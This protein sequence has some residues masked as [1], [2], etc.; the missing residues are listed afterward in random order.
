M[1]TL[2]SM[3]QLYSFH[4]TTA[5]FSM[6]QL[7]GFCVTTVTVQFP[8]HSC[9][10]SIIHVT[11]IWFPCHTVQ[12]PFHNCMV[13]MS[14]PYSFHLTAVWFPCHNRT[15][16]ISQLYG[17][18]VTTVHFPC[19]SCAVSI[20]QLNFMKLQ[21]PYSLQDHSLLISLMT[22]LSIDLHLFLQSASSCVGVI[23]EDAPP[24]CRLAQCH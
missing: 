19:H 7:C 23:C 14:Q 22:L 20:S 1:I 18:P 16:S 4:F 11:T 3:S 13:S 8:F 10:V 15:V 12:F 6:S 9:M 2:I 21:Q 17:F 5:Q 24:H